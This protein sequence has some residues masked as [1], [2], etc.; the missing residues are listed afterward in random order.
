MRPVWCFILVLLTVCSCGQSSKQS[1][2]DRWMLETSR[3]RVLCTTSMVEE[4]VR[5]VGHAH[6][7]THTLIR[8]ELDPHTYELVKGDDEKLATADLV[9]YSGLNLEH[10]SSLRYTLEAHP[11]AI[12]VAD[13]VAAID[14]NVAILIEGQPDPH[15]WTDISMWARTVD[16]VVGKLSEE[17][18]EHQQL[19]AQRGQS[20]KAEMLK[21]HEEVRA[22]MQSIPQEKRYLITSHDAFNYFCRAYMSEG[23]GDQWDVRCVAPEGLAPEGQLSTLDIQRIIDHIQRYGVQVIF[24]ES[25]VSRDSLRKIVDAAHEKGLPLKIAEVHLYADAMGPK[26][27]DG[28]TYLKMI[29]H[30]AR[31]IFENLDQGSGR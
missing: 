20:L 29:Q 26:G 7:V 6:I 13:V 23:A 1:D 14:P 30:N 15:L 27:S 22:L 31:A 5:R 19:F 8:G 4:V 12:G 2:T 11:N 28:D 18:P 25:N 10:G 3:L 21:T 9:V 24:P 17:I 16:V